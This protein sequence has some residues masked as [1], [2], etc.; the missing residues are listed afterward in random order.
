MM[1]RKRHLPCSLLCLG[2][3]L[4]VAG[5][6]VA[7]P[8]MA[9]AGAIAAAAAQPLA[10]IPELDLPRYM[11]R[12]HEIARLPNGFQKKCVGAATA[13]YTLRPDGRVRVVNRCPL[14]SGEV[15]VAEAEGRRVG[16]AGSPRL[17]VRFA[18]AWLSFLPFV[19]G[20]YWVVDLDPD[21]RLAAVGEPGRDYLW[22][23]ARTPAISRTDYEALLARLAAKGFDVT[24]LEVTGTLE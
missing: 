4:A 24:Q 6:V 18:P 1:T 3:A 22:I 17:K 7:V 8:A 10:T 15:S 9:D 11:G 13:D 23:L 16:A 14:A 2:L 19:W 12:W 21:Y 5:P 20:K